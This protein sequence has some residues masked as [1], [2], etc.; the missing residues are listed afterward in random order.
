[1]MKLDIG[2]GFR[3]R[4]DVN[5]DITTRSRA[6]LIADFHHLPFVDHVFDKVTAIH[7]LE[8]STNPLQILKELLRVGNEI[9]IKCPHRFSSI[10]KSNDHKS[11]FNRKW[12]SR[13]C[14]L[15]KIF[16]YSIDT[17]LEIFPFIRP[18]ELIVRL[19]NG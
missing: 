16:D 9:L 1:M 18:H 8:H 6:N 14:K 4:G 15:F 3:P 2:C 13:V 11:S 19:R 10:A 12:F 5:L 7:V 17:R